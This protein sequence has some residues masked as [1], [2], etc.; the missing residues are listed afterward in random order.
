MPATVKFRSEA[1]SVL[2]YRC[3]ATSDDAPFVEQ[4]GAHSI[5]Y[6]KRGSF[7]YRTRGLAY[8]L[9][10]GSILVGHCDDEF[11]CTHEHHDGGDECLSFHFSPE[12]AQMLDAR[13]KTWRAGAL[14]P[15]AELVVLGELA[16]AAAEQ[17]NDIGVDEVGLLFAARFVDT[18]SG[19]TPRARTISARDRRRAVHAALWLDAHAHREVDLETTAREAGLSAFHFLRVFADVIGVTP[20]QYLVRT[21]LRRAAQ[22]LNDRDRA[23]TDIAL[24][25]GFADLSNFV[26]TFHR[27]AGVSPR[28]FRN[29]AKGDRKIFQERIAART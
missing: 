9:V 29:A 16:Q 8:E 28:A 11:L 18:V 3:T 15:L 25:V 1:L 4:H 5:S 20:H 22:L 13:S 27:A 26:R 24:D 10:A 7:G 14:P 23:I 12:L 19:H 2:D 21:R 6:V 17:R